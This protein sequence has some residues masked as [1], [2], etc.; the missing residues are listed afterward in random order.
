VEEALEQ[1][2]NDTRAYDPRVLQTVAWFFSAGAEE[3]N[4]SPPID[5]GISEL[6]PGQVLVSNVEADD[7][8]LLFAAG[9]K[10]SAT[11]VERLLNYHHIHNIKEPIQV[12]T[13][14]E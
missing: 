7:G 13:P 8:R 3:A 14:L 5:V 4:M 1:M 12:S 11:I 10:L 9:Q 6:R 2:Q